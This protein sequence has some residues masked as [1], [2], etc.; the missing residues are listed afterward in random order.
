[1]MEAAQ[2]SASTKREA[3]SVSEEGLRYS[4]GRIVEAEATFSD[5]CQSAV[6]ASRKNQGIAVLS[7]PCFASSTMRNHIM[8]DDR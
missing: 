3:T 8:T 1:M 4:V 7:I 6:G 5:C 2:S